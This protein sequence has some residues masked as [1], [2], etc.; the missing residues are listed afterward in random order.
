MFVRAK[1]SGILSLKDFVGG[2]EVPAIEIEKSD[3]CAETRLTQ[4]QMR[5]EA[6]RKTN[7]VVSRQGNHRKCVEVKNFVAFLRRTTG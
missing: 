6:K 4:L 1:N 3:N 7:T 2:G 5:S